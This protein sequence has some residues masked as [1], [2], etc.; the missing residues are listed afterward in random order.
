MNESALARMVWVRTL[1]VH[2][3]AVGSKR[4][5]GQRVGRAHG[6]SVWPEGAGQEPFGRC[7]RRRNAVLVR[8]VHESRSDPTFGCCQRGGP[9]PPRAGWPNR[10]IRDLSLVRGDRI[11]ND[12]VDCPVDRRGS[13]YR[14]TWVTATDTCRDT[15][16][17]RSTPDSPIQGLKEFQ[18]GPLRFRREPSP[19]VLQ[20]HQ[21]TWHGRGGITAGNTAGGSQ[22]SYVFLSV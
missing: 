7:V 16:E 12:R 19:H 4:P 17:S 11:G 14:H 15:I 2:D 3:G 22:N 5:D 10:R 18:N 8:R 20:L 21:R 13:T 1:V 9:R 6:A